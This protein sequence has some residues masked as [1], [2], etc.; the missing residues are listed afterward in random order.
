MLLAPA[1]NV[2]AYA[3]VARVWPPDGDDLRLTLDVNG[4]AVPYLH[5]LVYPALSTVAQDWSKTCM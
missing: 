3:H 4:R 2:L 1:I 5:G